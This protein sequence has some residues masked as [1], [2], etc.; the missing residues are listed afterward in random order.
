[1]RDL[2]STKSQNCVACFEVICDYGMHEDGEFCTGP[3]VDDASC[4][5]MCNLLL[6]R[7]MNLGGGLC[8]CNQGL[9]DQ[10]KSTSWSRYTSVLGLKTFKYYCSCR[11]Y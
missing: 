9:A 3:H 11:Y 5:L 6:C 2:L 8:P 7:R 1:V 4:G 10:K